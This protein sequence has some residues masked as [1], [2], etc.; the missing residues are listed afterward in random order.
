M[1]PTRAESAFTFLI[2]KT[3][4]GIKPAIN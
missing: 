3:T 4:I 1:L 2:H